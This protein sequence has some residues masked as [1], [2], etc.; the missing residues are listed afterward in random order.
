MRGTVPHYQ[1]VFVDEGDI[2]MIQVVQQFRDIGYDDVIIPDRT[3]ETTCGAPWNA[4][5]AN[6]LGYIRAAM[7][8][9]D[10]PSPVEVGAGR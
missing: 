8:A 7:Q 10:R 9:V 3:P 6:A 2:H 1:E 5:M 4:G